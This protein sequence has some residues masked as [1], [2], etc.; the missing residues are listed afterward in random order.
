[1]VTNLHI[2]LRGRLLRCSRESPDTAIL[3]AQVSSSS[4]A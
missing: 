1:M 2:V 4:S 3:E